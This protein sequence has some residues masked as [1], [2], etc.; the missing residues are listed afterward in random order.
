M[1]SRTAIPHHPTEVLEY[2]VKHNRVETMNAAALE[3]I[4]LRMSEVTKH[5]SP[6]VFVTWVCNLQLFE[7]DNPDHSND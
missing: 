2:A 3:S 5:L 4:G 1:G 7:F 6:E